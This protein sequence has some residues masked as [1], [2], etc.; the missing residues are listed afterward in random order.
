MGAL[1]KFSKFVVYILSDDHIPEH[2]H[3]YSPKKHM[4]ECEAKITIKHQKVIFSKGYKPKELKLLQ[5]FV[6]TNKIRLIEKWKEIQD[7]QD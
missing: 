6:K 4:S 7:E 3:I 5:E 2:V 1:F